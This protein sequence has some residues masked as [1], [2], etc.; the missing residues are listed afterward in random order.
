[1]SNTQQ[2]I[3]FAQ[4]HHE[5]YLNELKEFLT[6]PSVSTLPA[7]KPDMQRAAEWVAARLSDL[8]MKNIQVMPTAGHPVVFGEWMGAPG[9][10]TLLVYGHYDVQPVDPLNE[11]T[12]P[13][14]EP[15]VRGD[16][17][18][19]R[20]ASDMKGQ[21]HAFLK[22]ADALMKNG[23]L[24]V[25]LRVFVEG[26]EELGSPSLNAFIAQHK[27]LLKCDIA[28]NTDSGILTP[29][30]PAL[31]VGLR[32]L[33]YFEI[34]V[35]GP[36]H[37]VHSGIF[38]GSIHNPAQALCEIIAGM[39][40]A[41]GHVTLPGYYD[42]VRNLSEEE[43]AEMAN[44]P[45]TDDEWIK[46]TGAPQLYGEKGFSTL[47]RIGARPTLEVNG[48][49]SGFTGEGIKTVLPAKAVAKIS[50]RLVPYQDPVEVGDQLIKYMEEH[51]P[52]TIT[53]EVK[54]MNA[55]SPILVERDSPGVRAAS[56]AL[57]AT[58]GAKPVFRLEG[59]TVPVV[60]MFR[61]HLGVDSIQMGFG[62]PDDNFHGPNEKLH[63]PNYY[64]GIEAFIR[65]LENVAQTS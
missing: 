31:V 55:A 61:N 17:L 47:E 36:A 25:N 33:A 7:H 30:T 65:F 28:L 60:S 49:L 62:L 63:L 5:R 57:Q 64:R 1:M 53:W 27:D 42:K 6:I 29:E 26:E 11:W 35:H 32:G 2:A 8:G 37:D 40:D 34:W 12:T 51:A 19:A 48:L 3:E 21:I 9:K 56:A 52:K 14:F 59:G 20:G 22:A 38:G 23:G 39:H 18:Y 41:N 24:P 13:P 58:F 44:V 43:R 50:M 15:T 46:M 45:Q 4:R 10:P 54:R 16:N